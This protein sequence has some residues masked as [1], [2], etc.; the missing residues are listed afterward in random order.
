MFKNVRRFVLPAIAAIVLLAGCGTATEQADH[1]D[2]DVTFASEMIPHHRQA[3][4]MAGLVT[5]RTGNQR[6]RGLA[7][8]I[9]QA[10]Q[11]EIEQLSEWLQQ[12]GEAV[13]GEH[14]GHGGGHAMPGM[15]TEEHL[16]ELGRMSGATFDRRWLELMIEHHAGAIEMARA[17]LA[18]GVH[19]ELKRLAQQVINTQQAEIDTMQGLLGNG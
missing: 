5:E 7:D 14:E 3:I 10:Q 13:P 6:L 1:N 4:E 17:Q 11:P 12:W 18:H 8:D 16:A 19:S 2:A 15:M 9:R